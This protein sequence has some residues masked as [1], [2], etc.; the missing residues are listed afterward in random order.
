VCQAIPRNTLGAVL[1][2][3]RGH[4]TD[5]F[6]SRRLFGNCSRLQDQNQFAPGWN[7]GE[8]QPW[9]SRS[10][11]LKCIANR[12]SVAEP[13][14]RETFPGVVP[15]WRKSRRNID[16]GPCGVLEDLSW[17]RA[18]YDGHEHLSPRGSATLASMT[19]ELQFCHRVAR[20]GIRS[21]TRVPWPS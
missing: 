5:P 10:T 13:F 16:P 8:A 7:Y 12:R 11:L 3:N 1:G 14:V 15:K 19:R 20:A 17:Q 4:R 18:V 6:H 2:M 9:H 21:V